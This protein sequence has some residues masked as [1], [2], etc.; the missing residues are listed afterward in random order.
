[1][2]EII[3]FEY[4]LR[5]V[6]DPVDSP[7][8]IRFEIRSRRNAEFDKE[9]QEQN[10]KLYGSEFGEQKSPEPP[11]WSAF[12]RECETHLAKKVKDLWVCAWYT[13]ALLIRDGFA[14]LAAGLKLAK[15]MI[16]QHWDVIEPRPDAEGGI[17][18]T[19]KMFTGL[20]NGT[21]FIDRLMMTPI[22]QAT[23]DYEPISCATAD[24]VD[25]NV[26]G[27][28]TG[29]TE[30]EFKQLLGAGIRDSIEN[31]AALTESFKEKCGDDAPPAARFR[32][33]L[34]S[35]E[36]KILEI[37]PTLIPPEPAEEP[38]ETGLVDSGSSQTGGLGGG[39]SHVQNREEAFK[40]LDQVARFFRENEPSSP[41]SY[42]LNQAVRWGRMSLP[43]LIDDLV[44]DT[45][46]KSLILKRTGIKLDE[47][48]DNSDS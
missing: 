26:R 29:A 39:G 47:G 37:Y 30:D 36:K 22:S 13:E 7:R 8:I 28:V 19:V 25:D 46:A 34:A 32:E 21:T 41:V 11:D 27:A 31:F 43:D 17:E 14:G 24:E 45:D 6:E 42:A 35:C 33:A 40:R 44:D 15:G 20:N 4:L 16:D 12:I 9:E 10:Y 38:G 1:M 18:D 2:E 23:G 5:P 3:D 48:S